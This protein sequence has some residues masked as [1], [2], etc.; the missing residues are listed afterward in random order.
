[1]R[2]KYGELSPPFRDIFPKDYFGMAEA[3]D[4]AADIDNSISGNATLL[5]LRLK[6]K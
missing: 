6:I 2:V 4:V 5:A 1:M 3:A